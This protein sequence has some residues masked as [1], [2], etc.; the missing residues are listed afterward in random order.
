MNW[1]N[2]FVKKL[3]DE[4][5]HRVG[6]YHPAHFAARCNVVAGVPPDTLRGE[7]S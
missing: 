1:P 5:E 3:I 6:Y 2:F 7:K 4:F